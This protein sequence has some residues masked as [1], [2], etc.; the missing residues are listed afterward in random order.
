MTKA[1]LLA[2]PLTLALALAGTSAVLA[3]DESAAPEEGGEAETMAFDMSSIPEVNQD[4][5]LILY[6]AIREQMLLAG[7]AEED[8]P[9]AIAELSATYEGLDEEDVDDIAEAYL[10]SEGLKAV[11]EEVGDGSF[12]FLGEDEE[13]SSE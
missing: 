9:A 7:V 8:I 6:H 13:E 1:R 3:Q 4:E 11:T 10:A 5:A 12:G 2:L